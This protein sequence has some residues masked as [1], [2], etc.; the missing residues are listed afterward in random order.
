MINWSMEEKYFEGEWHMTV[1]MQEISRERQQAEREIL[2]QNLWSGMEM[3]LYSL[4]TLTKFVLLPLDVA[5][6][7]TAVTYPWQ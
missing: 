1:F 6:E 4:H 5:F 2:D 3:W 7:A